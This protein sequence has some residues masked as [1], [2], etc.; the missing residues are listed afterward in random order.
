MLGSLNH[1]QQSVRVYGEVRATPVQLHV[2]RNYLTMLRSN[3]GP[4]VSH[5]ITGSGGARFF[6]NGKPYIA[7]AIKYACTNYWWISMELGNRWMGDLT[8]YPFKWDD[9]H[10]ALTDEPVKRLCKVCERT[11][12]KPL[13]LAA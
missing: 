1:I 4:G 13:A 8:S 11:G 12:I 5:I 7:V 6:W 3:G 10:I 9:T 2:K